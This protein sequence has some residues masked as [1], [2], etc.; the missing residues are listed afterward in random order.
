MAIYP[1]KALGNEQRE[2]WQETRL[3]CR[4]IWR[5]RATERQRRT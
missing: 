4:R 5:H 3:A 2:R 1:M